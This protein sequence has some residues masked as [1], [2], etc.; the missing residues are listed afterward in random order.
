MR[1]ERDARSLER[2]ALDQRLTELER[3][4]QTCVSERESACVFLQKCAGERERERELERLAGEETARE[5]DV[6]VEAYR[7]DQAT[8]QIEARAILGQVASQR[9]VA[10]LA[11][12]CVVCTLRY[13]RQAAAQREDATLALARSTETIAALRQ[14]RD[15]APTRRP[16][17]PFFDQNCRLSLSLSLVRVWKGSPPSRLWEV[18]GKTSAR[19]SLSLSGEQAWAECDSQSVAA[20]ERAARLE[21]GAASPPPLL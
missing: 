4:L 19:G 13:F 3:E 1:R 14:A 21:A 15:H 9:R 20:A 8:L 2:D 16:R 11:S 12:V 18:L 10:S 6:A 7:L 5:R 17:S